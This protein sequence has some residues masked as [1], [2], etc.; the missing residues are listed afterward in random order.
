MELSSYLKPFLVKAAKYCAYQERAHLEVEQKLKSF[1]LDEDDAAEIIF[2]LLQED[3]LN[4]ERYAKLYAKSKFNQNKWG[5]SKIRIE[6][7]R[8]EVSDRNIETGLK[9]IDEEE[10]QETLSTLLH[11]KKAQMKEPHPL[12][13]KK[14]LFDYA[15][16]KGYGVNNINLALEA[17][18]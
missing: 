8:K 9:E 15:Y 13:M 5:R 6:L 10:Y 18:L 3:Y 4:E 7:K 12:K 1:G 11:K 16:R 17:I 14:K 2:H